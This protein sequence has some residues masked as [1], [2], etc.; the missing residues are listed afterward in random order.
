MTAK[1]R[2]MIFG[3]KDDGTY[4]VEF[5]T[6]TGEA[7]DLNTVRQSKTF[8]ATSRLPPIAAKTSR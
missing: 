3:P 6:A 7:G 2:M 1:N 5:R 4:V 8:S